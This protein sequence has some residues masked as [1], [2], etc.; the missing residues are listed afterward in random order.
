MTTQTTALN[1]FFGIIGFFVVTI[2]CCWIMTNGVTEIHDQITLPACA[3][4]LSVRQD[5]HGQFWSGLT[6]M[7]QKQI[8]MSTS[9]DDLVI[10]NADL[11]WP[12]D[13]GPI[14]KADNRGAGIFVMH[15][16]FRED[17]DNNRAVIKPWGGS[18]AKTN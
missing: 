9:G 10:V 6:G 7:F 16:L 14:I 11:E 13:G 8:I 2:L 4:L 18:D 12:Q 1:N 17:K 15:D 3:D 5:C